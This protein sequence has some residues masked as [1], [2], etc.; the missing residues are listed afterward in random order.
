M[1]G[2]M[3]P[4]VDIMYV[5]G[6]MAGPSW[7]RT[8][9]RRRSVLGAH[10]GWLRGD[11]CCVPELH[12]L[13]VRGERRAGI[14]PSSLPFRANIFFALHIECNH[15][16]QSAFIAYTA[17]SLLPWYS[18]F[19]IHGVEVD[20]CS[21]GIIFLAVVRQD[22]QQ[23]GCDYVWFEQ[24]LTNLHTWGVQSSCRGCWIGT[25]STAWRYYH[26]Y[27]I[28]IWS[29]AKAT[30]PCGINLKETRESS[31]LQ[32]T[33]RALHEL[34]TCTTLTIH[35]HWNQWR[36]GGTTMKRLGSGIQRM[37]NEW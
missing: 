29:F 16:M 1:L 14:S 31:I 36:G 12:C 32:D 26:G 6:R 3:R 34:K 21:R 5:R 22:R 13:R 28:L 37:Q 11:D 8:L 18:E 27:I 4:D 35:K 30:K 24:I 10:Y 25:L 9:Q 17:G 33:S 7:Q 2:V 15:H 19:V 20:P 23:S